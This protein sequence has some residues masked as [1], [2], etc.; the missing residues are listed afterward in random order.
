LADP[1]FYTFKTNSVDGYANRPAIV[2][3]GANDGM[4]HVFSAADGAELYAYIPSML[5]H[6]LDRLAVV[7][8]YQHT[9][10]VGSRQP[11]PRSTVPGKPCSAADWGPVKKACLPWM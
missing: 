6:K 10:Y 8:P 2:A 4:L 3:V 9:Y 7:P 11:L 1:D 5:I